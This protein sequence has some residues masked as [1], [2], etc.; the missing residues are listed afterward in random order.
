M[1]QNVTP[2]HSWRSIR[3]L[4]E[5][6]Y[7]TGSISLAAHLDEGSP[8]DLLN[9]NIQQMVEVLMER[10]REILSNA[11][12]FAENPDNRLIA[13]VCDYIGQHYAENISLTTVA[14]H[15][16]YSSKYMSRLFKESMNWNLSDYIN[17][18]RIEKAKELLRTTNEPIDEIQELVGI[19]SRT[20][21]LRV[22]KKFEGITPGQYRKLKSTEE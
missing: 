12:V 13:S 4:F 10:F 5:R 19:P 21:F 14:E 18:V 3:Q 7:R 8:V 2:N 6:I 11:G 17:Y 9:C 1:K 22:F 20:T 15:V 16:G